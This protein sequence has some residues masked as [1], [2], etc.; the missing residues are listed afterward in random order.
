MYLAADSLDDLLIKVYKQILARGTAIRP[1][2]GPAREI[3][4]MLLKLSAPRVRLSRSE[5]RG[6]LFSCLGELLWILAGT[7]RL[8]FIQHYIPSYHEFSDDGKTIF[9]A[10]GPRLFGKSPNDQVHRVI[11][12]LGEKRDSRQAVLQ[13]F[14]RTDTLVPHCDIPCTCTL[15]FL[16]RDG[17]LHLLTSMRSNDAWLGLPHDVFTF[18]MLQELVARSLGIELGEYKHAVGSLHLY[19]EHHDKAL[20]FLNEGWQTHR[21]MPPMPKGD[22]WAAVKNLL[23][24]EKKVRT[25]R[26]DVPVPHDTMDTYWADLATLLAIYKAGLAPNN[27]PEIKRLKRRIQDDVYSTYIKR[28]YK[29]TPEKEQLSFFDE[30][31]TPT[32]E[33][34]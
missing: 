2:K 10:Y 17:R 30:G 8:D 31:A 27:Q 34:T 16:V 12:L 6:L 4:G 29:L 33:P 25:D 32:K 21:P 14:D 18:T 9:G 22:P 19:D 23:E 5:S 13:L 7:K 1:S 28:R 3:S 24:F 15:Q 11:K 20:R 26:D